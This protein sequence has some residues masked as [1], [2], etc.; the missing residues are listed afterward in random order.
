M[1]NFTKVYPA[2]FP[3][4][5]QIPSS[6]LSTLDERVAKCVNGDDGG[7]WGGAVIF[8][9]CQMNGTS[10]ADTTG[11]FK[12]AVFRRRQYS[13]TGL[14]NGSNV[15]CDA[16][17]Y[18]EFDLANAASGAAMAITLTFS[19]VL[20]GAEYVVVLTNQNT[21]TPSLTW[22]GGGITHRFPGGPT[23]DGQPSPFGPNCRDRWIG[24]AVSSTEIH[25]VA[26]RDVS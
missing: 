25:W 23:L 22:A 12:A 2:G 19:N 26:Q 16:T 1:A 18:S 8:T 24:I 9:A 3:F 11:V 7:T 4:E 20:A 14:T 15:A 17:A 21:V 10:S 5:G 13:S 6:F